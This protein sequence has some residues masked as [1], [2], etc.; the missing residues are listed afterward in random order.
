MTNPALASESKPGIQPELVDRLELIELVRLERL[1]RDKGDWERLATAFSDD[2]WIRT[3]WFA[4]GTGR[5]FVDA[6]R[7]MAEN[8]RHSKHFI[9]PTEVQVNGDR[10]LVESI[11]EIHNR[12]TI[13]AIEVDMVMYCRFFSRARRGTD[14]WKLVTFE[15]LYQWDTI[16]PVNPGDTVPIDWDEVA[17]LRPAYRIWAWALG[18]RGY[19]VPQGDDIVAGDRP[20]L[21][22]AFYQAADHWLETGEG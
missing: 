19:D 12:S 4:G 7:A 14:G 1:W 2:S 9:T 13:D 11:G 17:G 8:G 3:T 10:A 20:D 18:K 16:A 5:E 15:G 21:V 22:A 6:S